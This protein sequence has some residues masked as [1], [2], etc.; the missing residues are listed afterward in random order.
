MKPGRRSLSEQTRA[1][2]LDLWS[3]E[4][5]FGRPLGCVTTSFT[6]DAELFEEQCLARF[7][8]IQSNPNE[9]AKAYLVEREEKL[10]Q[11]FSCVLVDRAHAAPDRS[12]RW[13]LLPVTLP[14]GG[15]LHA[16]ITLLVWERFV[17]VIIGSANL[18]VP[19]YRQNQEVVTALDFGSQ[20]GLPPVLLSQC[21]SFLRQVSMFAHGSGR[22]LSGPHATLTIFLNSVEERVAS[23]PPAERGDD[24]CTLIPLIPGGETVIKQLQDVWKGSA[25]NRAWVLSPFYDEGDKA[26]QTAA[27][28]AS[29]LTTKGKRDLY[30][31][32]P[33]RR[34]PDGTVQIDCS[35][36]LKHSSH[37]SLHHGFSIVDERV[38]VEGK[39]EQRPLHAKAIWLERDERAL[40]LVGSSNFTAAGLGLHPAHN[41]EL[42][43][44]YSIKDT[45]L[46]FGR[47]C[48]QSWPE[49]IELLQIDGVQFLGS[50]EDSAHKTDTPV[51][52]SAFGMALYNLDAQ[53]AR[54]E[55][56][57]GPK[58]PDFKVF[59]K[60]GALLF[61]S[62]EWL[63][64]GKPALVAVAWKEVRPP[65]SL[66][67]RWTD[68]TNS[69]CLASWI[70]NVADMS[71]LPPPDELGS[72]SLAELMEILSSARPM[73]EVI[74]GIL[75]RRKRERTLDL[76]VELDPHKKV[77][78]S[79]FLLQRM[80]RVARALEGMGK[81]LEQPVGSAE[82]LNWRLRGPIGPISLAKRLAEEDPDGAAFMIAEVAATL[83][84]VA[85]Q[86]AGSLQT[87]DIN[88]GVK[89]AVRALHQLASE[90]QAP[91]NLAR[92]VLTSFEGLLR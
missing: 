83:L 60:S 34:L 52:P 75:D 3:G 50:P 69:E 1:R 30:F 23:L 24:E 81:R 38:E 27:C 12:L 35:E 7:L 33:G 46:R 39:Q 77:D 29:L 14:R 44:A 91:A 76:K 85:W 11:C 62:V 8:S 22:A 67:V 82:A 71:A 51:L 31:T 73:H 43:V 89:D 61:D 40:Y 5:S 54:L 88:A 16:K 72:L 56:D 32:A 41:I 28:F 4:D 87:S 10:S 6:F 68:E 15:F 49:E 25:P 63:R 90:R 26:S 66:D 74:G 59:S 13:A 57:I 79:H 21:V 65:S 42:N 55:L 45:G 78:T 37:P 53:G 18:T 19:A 48:A 58:A 17:R 36:A 70:V 84:G 2:L 64:E 92:Y 9:T 80:R 86:P 20:A 47:L